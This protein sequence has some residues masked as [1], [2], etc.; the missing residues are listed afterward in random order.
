[1]RRFWIEASRGPIS[2]RDSIPTTPTSATA[3]PTTQYSPPEIILVLVH[4]G[5]ASSSLC[6]GIPLQ[7]DEEA[8][9]RGTSAGMASDGDIRGHQCNELVVVENLGTPA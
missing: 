4:R 6:M 2:I 9:P 3:P 1:M 5:H 7:R 8:L